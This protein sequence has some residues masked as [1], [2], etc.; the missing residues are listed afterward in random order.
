MGQDPSEIRQEVEQTRAQMGETVEA[1]AYRADVKERAKESAS[2]KLES[3]KGKASGT[4]S[5]ARANAKETAS[6]LSS[7]AQENPLGVAVGG[8][9]LG[10]LAGLVVPSSKVEE[11]KLGP[12]GEELRQQ[13]AKTGQEALE[14]GKQVAQQAA[15]TATETAKE[16]AQKQGR[17][18]AEDAKQ[19]GQEVGSRIG[20]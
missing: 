2:E 12:A 11:D 1:L 8:V 14:R 6:R 3:V 18:L 7:T 13:A 16:E 10:L 20:S 4:S 19:S 17:E 5:R 9:A 15:Q